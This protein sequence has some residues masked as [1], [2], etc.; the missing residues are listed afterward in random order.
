GA[1][2]QLLRR[3]QGAEA[4]LDE[5]SL[6]RRLS[7]DCRVL[8]LRVPHPPQRGERGVLRGPILVY[9][10]TGESRATHAD[11]E[12]GP[13]SLRLPRLRSQLAATARTGLTLVRASHIRTAN[14]D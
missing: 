7:V 9:S 8:S 12:R 2:S 5:S 4:R 3:H 14:L 1:H 10:G 6:R 13:E 11:S